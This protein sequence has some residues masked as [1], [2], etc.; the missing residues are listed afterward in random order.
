M[1][2]FPTQFIAGKA[3]ELVQV[4]SRLESTCEAIAAFWTVE[5]ENFESQGSKMAKNQTKM[6][7]SLKEIVVGDNIAFWTKAK[8]EMDRYVIAMS[9]VNNCFNFVTEAKPPKAQSVELTGLGITL[10]VPKGVDV[11][12]IKKLTY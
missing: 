6:V 7:E 2:S 10:K 11:D 5:A 12:A 3:A 4:L 9:A 1:H 8:D